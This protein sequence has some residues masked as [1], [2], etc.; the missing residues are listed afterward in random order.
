VTDSAQNRRRQDQSGGRR[1]VHEQVILAILGL[2]GLGA[3]LAG[4]WWLW[5][6][7]IATG[8]VRDGSSNWA[9]DG[10]V[11][12]SSEHGGKADLF[13]ADRSGS[14]R[15]QLTTTNGDEGGATY[16]VD[17]HRIAFHSDRD[18]N[19]EI[20]VR[21]ADSETTR[22]LTHDPA[23]DQAPTWSRDGKQI[24]FMSDRDNPDFDL[25]RMN[26]DGTGDV[27]RLTQ[28]KSNR[29]P[30][31]SPDGGQLLLQVDRDVYIMSLSTLG[32][33]RVTHEPDNGLYPTWAPDGLHIAF[34]S[35][36]NGHSQIFTS[37]P[38]GGDPKVVV[39][40]PN[41][42]AISPRWSPDGK[43]ISFVHVPEGGVTGVQDATQQR[44]VY[45]VELASGRV[46]RVS[47]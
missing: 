36:R 30:Q 21:Q 44:I 39:S 17:G 29:F 24:V 43:Y 34:M 4:G 20:Y 16:S 37:R 18:G 23:I 38:D 10:R 15:V 42:D 35:W 31:Y 46:S 22:Q 32:L 6:Q 1:P 14:N 19:F 26:T 2:A 9:P 11:I 47:R 40:M 33:R 28:G 45:V 8:V 3:A 41:G 25:Y 7:S 5:T 12:F 13:L 27:E